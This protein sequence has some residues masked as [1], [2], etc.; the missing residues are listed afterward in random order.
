[1][2]TTR[3]EYEEENVM[4]PQGITTAAG[5]R[6]ASAAPLGVALSVVFTGAASA[7]TQHASVPAPNPTVS[8][9]RILTRTLTSTSPAQNHCATTP[10]ACGFPDGTNTGVPTGT[11]LLTVPGQVST[12]PGW[13]FDSRGW[14]EVNGNGAKLSGLYIPYTLDI[15][16]SNVTIKH[17]RVVTSGH[18]SFGVSV[19]HTSNVTIEN[20]TISGLNTGAG[21]VMVGVKDIYADSTGLQILGNNISM[22]ATGVQLESGLVQGNYIHNLGYISGDHLNGVTSN[23]GATALLTIAHNTAFTNYQQT[24]AISLFE[25]F[26]AQA[27]RVITGNL[28]AG[29]GYAIYGGQ[30]TG[31]PTATNIRITNNRIATRIFPNGGFYGPVA[32][33]NTH[34]AGNTWT[35][36]VWDGTGAAVPAL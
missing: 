20:S 34:G 25:D 16:A 21:R 29:G 12:G 28:L 31:G 18:S 13:Y 17:V 14:V 3:S 33:F 4:A 32:Y 2:I 6:V 24:D 22:A 10:S 35:G 15:S 27:N 30:N 26:G 8:S 11:A 9:A 23:G 1:V 5:H 36:N 19:R 7:S